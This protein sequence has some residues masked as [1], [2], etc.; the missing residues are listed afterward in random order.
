M[1]RE[2]HKLDSKYTADVCGSFRRGEV[3]KLIKA[4]FLNMIKLV[5]PPITKLE[6]CTRITMSISLFVYMSVHV[7]SFVQKIS[8]EQLNLL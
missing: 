1:I 8:S 6:G 5:I 2:V 7:S 4:Q 3:D